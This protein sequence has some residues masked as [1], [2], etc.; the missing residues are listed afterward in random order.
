MFLSQNKRF[1]YF[2]A[3]FINVCTEITEHTDIKYQTNKVYS[4]GFSI[5]MACTVMIVK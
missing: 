1:G 3:A 5:Y 2:T 4:Y